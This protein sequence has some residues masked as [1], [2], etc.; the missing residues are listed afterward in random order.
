MDRKNSKS[1]I[2]TITNERRK[3]TVENRYNV[4]NVSK[5][6]WVQN[7]RKMSFEAKK[8]ILIF[9]QEPKVHIVDGNT[10]DIYRLNINIANEWLDKYHPFRST[11][12]NVLALGLVKNNQ[13]YCLMTFKKSRNK[14][15]DAELSRMWM[16][17]TYNIKHGYDILSQEASNFG[18]NNIIA[19]VNMSFE[20]Y[21][22]YESIGM[23]HIRT[24]QKTLWWIRKD[25]RI[26]DA[27]RRQ[28]QFSRGLRLNS[29]YLPVDDCGQRVYAFK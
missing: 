14:N 24:N 22:D 1:N 5:L 25:E 27:S 2:N 20:N 16:L 4:D 12:G 29:G 21:K 17:P 9:Y 6:Q 7:K 26:S 19:Y 3:K 8:D 28:K 15:Y 23:K 13:I 11:K 18:I 10:L